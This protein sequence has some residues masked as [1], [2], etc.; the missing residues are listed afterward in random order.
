M[1]H[2]HGKHLLFYFFLSFFFRPVDYATVGAIDNGQDE[3]EERVDA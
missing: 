3:I 1:Y 2:Q